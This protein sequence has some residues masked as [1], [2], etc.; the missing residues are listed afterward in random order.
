VFEQGF[1]GSDW[2]KA[3]TRDGREGDE[4]LSFAI[5]VRLRA[6]DLNEH[7]SLHK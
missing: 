5:L 3:S 2:T 6:S 1:E 7:S 4:D